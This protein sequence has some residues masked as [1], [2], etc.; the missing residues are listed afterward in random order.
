MIAHS[1]KPALKFWIATVVLYA[2]LAA[3]DLKEL[4]SLRRG[5]GV[6]VLVLAFPTVAVAFGYWLNLLLFRPLVFKPQW[7]FLAL[8]TAISFGIFVPTCEWLTPGFPGANWHIDSPNLGEIDIVI[9]TGSPLPVSCLLFRHEPVSRF[10]QWRENP[11]VIPIDADFLRA[12]D[13]T[14]FAGSKVEDFSA[15]HPRSTYLYEI[16]SEADGHRLGVACTPHPV[17][18]NGLSAGPLP[19]RVIGGF[20]VWLRNHWLVLLVVPFVLAFLMPRFKFTSRTRGFDIVLLES[21]EMVD[22]TG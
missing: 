2:P 18:C 19:E 3:Y 13:M 21:S 22:G 9:A 6:G 14:P 1:L 10:T 17:Q 5:C 16:Q 11:R 7:L 20:A 12:E 4:V 8:V 15:I